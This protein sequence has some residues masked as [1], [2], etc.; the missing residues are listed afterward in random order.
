VNLWAINR[1][2]SFRW[3]YIFC[4]SF[5]SVSDIRLVCLITNRYGAWE[6]LCPVVEELVYTCF[7]TMDY[8]SEWFVLMPEQ[9]GLFYNSL[10]AHAQIILYRTL[11]SQAA[12]RTFQYKITQK[13]YFSCLNVLFS[14]CVGDVICPTSIVFVSHYAILP[15]TFRLNIPSRILISGLQLLGA[16]CCY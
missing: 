9:L 6:P 15:S 7:R 2:I 12:E 8:T 13:K 10:F 1:L 16:Y 5:Y 3:P 4:P 14:T 11:T